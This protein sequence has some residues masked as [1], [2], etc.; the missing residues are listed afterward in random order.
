MTVLKR[1]LDTRLDVLFTGFIVIVAICYNSCSALSTIEVTSGF[2]MPLALLACITLLR[3]PTVSDNSK[4]MFVGLVIF[5]APVVLSAA[6]NPSY[7]NL[8]DSIQLV[9][10]ILLAYLC[11]CKLG[12]LRFS[13]LFIDIMCVTSAGSILLFFLLNIIGVDLPLPVLENVNG[14]HYKTILVASQFVE[15]YIAESYSMGFFWEGGIFASYLMLAIIAEFLIKAKPS[16]VRLALLVVALLS[17]RSTAGYLLLP[18]AISV[19]ILQRGGKTRYAIA[20]LLILFS[21]LLAINLDSI[22]SELV[23][24][25]PE[26]FGKLIDS[27]A[28]TRLSRLQSPMACWTLFTEKPVFGFGYGDAFNAYSR[29]IASSAT[30][31]SLTSTSGFQLVA[32]GFGGFLMWGCTAYSVLGSRF[33][34]PLSRILLAVFIFIVI[35]KEPHTASALTYALLFALLSSRKD[36]VAADLID[37]P[38]IERALHAV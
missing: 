28:V 10:I 16:K 20:S 14:V 12:A 21:I 8:M 19:G 24:L 26:M 37:T 6:A 33:I 22:V 11:V 30:I 23:V 15:P 31:D 4:V 2:G 3:L 17:T 25:N 7:L 1:I 38:I 13:R 36:W 32:F 5:I 29:L 18:M 27:D 9:S 35:N 34:A